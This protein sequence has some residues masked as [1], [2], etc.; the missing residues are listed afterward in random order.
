[1]PLSQVDLQTPLVKEDVRTILEDLLE[2]A[3]FPIDAWQDEGVARAFLETQ[4]ALGAITS[5]RIAALAKQGFLSTAEVEY[6]T[7]LV[8]SHYDE[9]RNLATASV[10]PVTMVNSGGVTHTPAAGAV[11]F[12][13]DDGQTFT[14]LAALTLPLNS[15]TIVS[16]Q[17]QAVGAA[18]NIEAQTL[19]LVTPLAGVVATFAGT[20]TSAG[21]DAESDPKL[22]ER[23]RTKWAMLRVEKVRDGV[24][25]LARNAA[26]AIHGVAI[27]D[28]NPRGAGTVDVYLAAQNATAGG[29]DVTAVQTALDGAFFGNGTVDQ[30]VQAF[31][32]PTVAQAVAATI[33]VRGVTTAQAEAALAVAWADFLVSIPVGGFD[34]TPGPTNTI[35]R[36]MI[37]AAL[38]NADPNILAAD[39][40]SPAADVTVDATSKVLDGGTTFTVVVLA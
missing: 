12:R 23:A 7:A 5:D 2:D 19:E 4:A 14:N 11:V 37:I 8:K 6:L 16:V 33:Y 38:G 17:A 32:A 22:R 27:D 3:G 20:F 39:V 40:T 30:L 15:T 35:P 13:S 28:E 9:D 31:P 18:G 36:G 26:V 29:A 1:M 10:F 34:L 25:N 24:L 21:T